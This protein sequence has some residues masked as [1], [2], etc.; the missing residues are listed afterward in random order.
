MSRWAH[1]SHQNCLIVNKD[2]SRVDQG[3]KIE[4]ELQNV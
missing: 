2:G 1:C 3:D 4:G